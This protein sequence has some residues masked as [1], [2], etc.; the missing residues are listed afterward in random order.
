MVVHSHVQVSGVQFHST[1]PVPCIACS[2]PQVSNA[3]VRSQVSLLCVL[4][5]TSLLGSSGG[6]FCGPAG[7]RDAVALLLSPDSERLCRWPALNCV[8]T[9]QHS[10]S[11][12]GFVFLFRGPLAPC[13]PRVPRT[14]PWKP[15]AWP[16]PGPE[17]DAASSLR[18][19]VKTP[20]TPLEI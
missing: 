4:W 10:P 17:R 5:V 15:L 12:V 20:V 13:G 19:Q 2:P 8:N 1:S 9:A 7:L 3:C 18:P 14:A 11:S 6:D 16:S